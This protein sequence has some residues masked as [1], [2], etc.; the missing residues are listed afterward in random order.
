MNNVLNFVLIICAERRVDPCVER[1]LDRHVQRCIERSV[2]RPV[3]WIIFEHH[4][5]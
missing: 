2:E 3:K 1:R 4:D 5:E